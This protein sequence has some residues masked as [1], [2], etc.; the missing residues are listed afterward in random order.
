MHDN[1]GE[2]IDFDECDSVDVYANETQDN[3]VGIYLDKV[4]NAWIHRNYISNTNKQSTAMLF[5]IEAYTSLI[6]NHYI[7]NIK[8]FKLLVLYSKKQS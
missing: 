6:T 3:V 4:T 1:G 7:K 5:G 2:G 8:I